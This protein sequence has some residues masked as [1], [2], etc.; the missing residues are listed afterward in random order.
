MS[1]F[2]DWIM[3]FCLSLYTEPVQSWSEWLQPKVRCRGQQFPSILS[4]EARR[5]NGTCVPLY[6][7][8]ASGRV[9]RPTGLNETPRVPSGVCLTEATPRDILGDNE[10]HRTPFSQSSLGSADVRP[11]A[12][13]H[14]G[15][16]TTS[17]EGGTGYE[18]V[19][20]EGS[21]HHGCGPWHRLGDRRALHSGGNERRTEPPSPRIGPMSRH[22]EHADCGL[23]AESSPRT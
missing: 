20:R 14:V 18:G 17:R 16:G 19:Q 4:A 3:G 11:I 1:T 6:H 12:Q 13:L 9:N 22:G 7:S 8:E 10:L 15:R 21:G 23:G 5:V 2:C